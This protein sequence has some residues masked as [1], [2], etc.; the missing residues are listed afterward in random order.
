MKNFTL[1]LI[2][3]IFSLVAFSQNEKLNIVVIGAHPDDPD[4]STGGTA[5]KFAR[6]G[7][8]VL[9]VSVTNGDAGHFATGGGALAKRRREEAQEA[10]RRFGVTYRVMD[11]HDGELTADLNIRLDNTKALLIMIGFAV[12]LSEVSAYVLGK[13]FASH[14]ILSDWIIAKEISP[15]KTYIGVLGNMTGALLGIGIMYFAIDT[16]LAWFH[17]VFIG[18]L[19]GISGVM[20]DLTESMVKYSRAPFP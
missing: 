2:L 14:A 13:W 19:M 1:L 12:P 7:H 18:I 3:S 10:G 6:L 16:Y 17:W 5:I 9:F 15:N 4:V 11:N 20:G 8:N